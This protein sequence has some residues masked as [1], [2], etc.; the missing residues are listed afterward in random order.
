M[1]WKNWMR[2]TVRNEA[3]EFGDS[4][5]GGGSVDTGGST[6]S[7]MSTAE[8]EAAVTSIG[9]GL[10]F[11]S[12]DDDADPDPAAETPV[13]EVK[14][15]PVA[16]KPAAE[17][18]APTGKPTPLTDINVPPASW[19]DAAKGE[20]A[21]LPEA[22][23]Q[24][25]LKR[26]N[27]MFEGIAQYKDNAAVGKTVLNVLQPYMPMMQQYNVNPAQHID[28]LMRTHQEIITASPEG[29]AQRLMEIGRQYGID[30]VPR[31][32]QQREAAEDEPGSYVDP[33][34]TKLTERFQQIESTQAQINAERHQQRVA[35]IERSIAEFAAK[36]ENVHFDLVYAEMSALIGKGLAKDLPDAYA[37]AVRLNPQAFALETARLQTEAAEKA[38]KEALEKA[39]QVKRSTAAN[40]SS[41]ARDGSRTTTVGSWE[42]TMKEIA[43]K[44]YSSN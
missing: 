1:K 38:K 40:V 5:S 4:G 22:A 27:D 9:D 25:I 23:R 37:K 13:A 21:N 10:G 19:R 7:G 41:K 34:V 14:K 26:E 31:G 39:A 30:L 44:H 2:Y 6:E 11:N 33:A 16:E 18:P 15:E 32:S 3:G 24:E 8:L 17:T 12:K 29:K 43:D 28:N 42:D 36:P 35:E 20:W